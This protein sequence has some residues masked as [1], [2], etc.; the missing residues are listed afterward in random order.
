MENG[1][2][3]EKAYFQINKYLSV[4]LI[5]K[6][7]Q[8]FV[9]DEPFRQCKYL[10]LVNPQNDPHEPTINSID[11][12]AEILNKDLHT[13]LTPE[14]LNIKAEDLFWGHCSNLQA[15]AENDYDTRLLH[16]N[17]AFPLLRKL[18][19]VG[20]PQAKRK[21]KEEIAKR[22]IEGNQT[23][24][25]YLREQRYLTYLNDEELNMVLTNFKKHN[26]ITMLDLSSTDL[27]NLPKA[28]GDFNNLKELKLSANKLDTLPKRFKNLTRLERIDLSNNR[29]THIPPSI[30]HLTSLKQLNFSS[31]QIRNIPKWI[32]GTDKPQE[33]YFSDQIDSLEI[34]NLNNNLLNRIPESIGNLSSLK[35]LDLGHNS[36]FKIPP[37]IGNLEHLEFLSVEHNQLNSIPNSIG[38]L[39]SLKELN[40]NNNRL[41]SLPNTI[42]NLVNLETL[43]LEN[44]NL[45][46]IPSS[47]GRLE[48]LRKVNLLGN[49]LKMLPESFFNLRDL[50]FISLEFDNIPQFPKSSK[51]ALKKAIARGVRIHNVS[52]NLMPYKI[53]IV[54]DRFVGKTSLLKRMCGESFPYTYTLTVGVQVSIYELE[55][56]NTVIPVNIW[57]IG[58]DP[59]FRFIIDTFFKHSLG[60]VIVYD[61]SKPLTEGYIKDWMIR[62]RKENTTM[63]IILAGNK[64]D[65]VD[66]EKI[67]YLEKQNLE[68]E[69]DF[70]D[71]VFVTAKHENPLENIIKK[72]VKKHTLTSLKF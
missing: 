38:E 25:N 46:L 37:T 36:L 33:V 41:T 54:G 12:A 34:L 18:S 56:N 16:R 6:K 55:I 17:L 2:N 62:C 31:N 69:F 8:I 60:A 1:N 32:N 57:D 61:L 45:N 11:E 40:L 63:P 65:L 47:I 10:F 64:K 29:F 71:H 58:G 59:R 9:N 70:L 13:K 51:R 50:E 53:I 72:L 7:T 39:N 20:D 66:K 42:Q 28:M 27:E 22:F 21:F 26:Q 23:V 48:K 5:N 15:W 67:S 24:I 49:S 43:S 44:N 14:D 3:K 68:N 52:Y 4:K 30:N 19:T 35:K